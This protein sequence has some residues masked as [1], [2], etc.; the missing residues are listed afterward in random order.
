VAACLRVAGSLE[1]RVVAVV[2]ARGSVGG[3]CARLL[4]RERPRRLLLI[5]RTSV[6]QF[7]A[8]LGAEAADLS[9]LWQADLIVSAAA[10]GR[11]ILGDAPIRPGTIICDVARPADAPPALRARR[12]VTVLDGGLVSL[13]DP[14]LRFGA[15]NLQGLPD[16]VAL[17]CLAETMLL[18]LAG[19]TRDRGVGETIWLDEADEIMALATRHG[20][21]LPSLPQLQKAPAI[22]GA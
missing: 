22:G 18:A 17:A 12:D 5:G 6:R 21:G 7:A 3:L 9:A 4:Q 15:G 11:P 20:F 2:G 1:D 14:S 16:G 10:A 8:E 19:E 13:P